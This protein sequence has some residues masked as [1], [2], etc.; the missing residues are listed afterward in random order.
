I[1]EGTGTPCADG[2]ASGLTFLSYN[3]APDGD[4]W[5]NENI[6]LS[7]CD[8]PPT[9]YV[10]TVGDCADD[11]TNQPLAAFIYPVAVEYCDGVDN[12]CNGMLDTDDPNAVA[13]L[14]YPDLDGDGF[15]DDGAVPDE[16]CTPQT[17]WVSNGYDCDDANAGVQPLATDAICNGIDDN[18]D[19][20][21]DEEAPFTEVFRDADMDG[22]GG[23]S[24]ADLI[25][26][27]C[28]GDD[29]SDVSG[30]CDD[31]DPD[32]HPGQVDD[33][34]DGVDQDCDGTADDGA[35]FVDVPQDVD[36]DGFAGDTTASEQCPEAIPDVEDCDDDDPGVNPDATED[37]DDVDRDCDGVAG[38]DQR[39]DCGGGSV[40]PPPEPTGCGCTNSAA[41]ASIGLIGGLLG[42]LGLRRRA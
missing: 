24:L 9:G 30:D 39:D 17:G 29:T 37:C 38:R 8:G 6:S 41:P 31:Q 40:T 36:G 3:P 10:G 4:G 14:W 27:Q 13:G 18:C 22:F 28:P 1:S 5:G 32:I 33:D 21:T 26:V 20:Q 7:T 11:P 2:P 23:T 25:S 42:L 15:G 19:G 12:D 35:P 16:T 34:C